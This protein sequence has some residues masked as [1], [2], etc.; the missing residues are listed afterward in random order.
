MMKNTGCLIFVLFLCVSSVFGQ[1]EEKEKKAIEAT[2]QLYFDGM[3]ERDRN[4][5]DQ[6]FDPSAR[7]IGYRGDQFT[8]TPYEDWASG[9]ASGTQ[10]RD[11]KDFDNRLLEIEIKGYTAVVRTELFWPG[12]YYYDFL[13][14][15][16]IDGDWKIVHKTW[17]EEKR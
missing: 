13:T 12:V 3:V 15:V 7:L 5:L 14:L 10:K 17:Y 6:A 4:K 9:T 1:G 11:P 8:V 2:V 16:K